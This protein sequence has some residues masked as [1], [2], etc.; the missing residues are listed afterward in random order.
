[1]VPFH[2][3]PPAFGF[4]ISL[5]VVIIVALLASAESG[6]GQEIRDEVS[7]T[8]DIQPFVKNYC[9]TC[10]AGKSPEGKVL[11]T[12]YDQ[13][14]RH[15]EK[16]KLLQRIN[17]NDKPMP[18]D[19]LLPAY[20]RRLFRVWAEG[21]YVNRG[22]K[23]VEARSEDLAD[24]T[25]PQIDPVDVDKEGFDL[26]EKLQGH[27]VGSMF[28]L[29]QN[30]DWMAFDY[31]AIGPAHVHGIYEGG[32]M[33]NLFTSFFVA[34]YKGQR[35]IM[36]RNGGILNGIYRTSY[37]V[38]DR[39]EKNRGQSSYR[40]VDAYGGKDIMWME[41]SFSGDRIKFDSYT[42]R[43][44]LRQ[45]KLHMSFKARRIHPELAVEAAK[46]VGFPDKKAV[47]RDFSNGLPKPTWVNEYPQT[48]ASYIHEDSTLSLLELAQLAKDPYRIDQ[49]PHLSTLKISIK[50]DKLIQGTKLHVYLSIKPLTDQR[51]RFVTDRF[52]F[53]R[54][55][56]LNGLLQFPE[57]TAGEKEFTFTYLHP[58]EYYLT[59]V[60]DMDNDSYP[61]PGDIVHARQRVNVKPKSDA[62][63]ELSR[64]WTK[65]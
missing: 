59:V 37:F 38:L 4:G 7:W 56:L 40:L 60:A 31:R 27:W 63:I 51:G 57:L 21:G 33:G 35:T 58:G 20:A 62:K 42:S 11:L 30:F 44:G 55:E 3:R 1:M 54:E 25:P 15:V 22:R 45:P 23:Q 19:G 16:G 13:V 29:G 36:A 43:F 34:K 9:T 47:D 52:G 49:M 14:R 39:V 50:R 61:S 26:L 65:N 53:V 18:P 12:T 24:W 48:S 5:S 32:T 46:A 6:F 17:N 10:H 28:L 41:L 64:P 8:N 2:F